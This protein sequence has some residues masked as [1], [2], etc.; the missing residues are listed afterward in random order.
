M[1][2]LGPSDPILSEIRNIQRKGRTGRSNIGHVIILITKDTID[3]KNY[4]ISYYN[5][6]KMS[7]TI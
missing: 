6:K 1:G 2:L 3:E 7:E 4:W 5:E